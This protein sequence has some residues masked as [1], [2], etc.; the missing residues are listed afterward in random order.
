MGA[1]SFDPRPVRLA[2]RSVELVPLAREHAPALFEEAREPEIWTY[3]S[4]APPRAVGDVAAWI[5]AALR[6]AEGG[7]ELPFAVLSRA[8]GRP[9]GSTRYLDVERRHRRLE[10]GWT[11]LGAAHRRTAANTECK[12]LLLEHAF[13]VLGAHRVQFK[14]DER[15]LRSRRALERIGAR[16]E[17][18]LRRHMVLPDGFV[19][20]SAY[21]SVVD[22]DWPA[23]RARLEALLGR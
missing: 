20:D 23:T 2:G 18:T 11:W 19:R 17:G 8:D 10:V 3:L 7:A 5:E 14:T 1:P 15:N 16:Y 4:A 6:A 12:L 21:Y 13:E 22:L 9:I